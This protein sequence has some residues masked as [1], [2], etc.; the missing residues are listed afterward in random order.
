MLARGPGSDCAYTAWV[1]GLCPLPQECLGTC[2]ASPG[3]HPASPPST[4]PTKNRQASSTP[5]S[6]GFWPAVVLPAVLGGRMF[7]RL[8][9][10]PLWARSSEQV[11]T[12]PSG[13]PALHSVGWG[14]VAGGRGRS[15]PVAELQAQ[16]AVL[17]WSP[18]A[19]ATGVGGAGQVEQAGGQAR[20]EK[21]LHG[22]HKGCL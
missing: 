7:G 11:C 9:A 20:D 6:L 5:E 14:P 1:G 13:P 18:V 19:A 4:C 8:L 3:P 15:G 17:R 2:L 22:W 10:I 21:A 16:P 12:G